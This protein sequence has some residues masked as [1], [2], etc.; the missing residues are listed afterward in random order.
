MG[1]PGLSSSVVCRLLE[2]DRALGW[3]DGRCAE[4]VGVWRGP[5]DRGA[6]VPWGGPGYDWRNPDDPRAVLE[7]ALRRLSRRARRELWALVEPADER[8]RRRWVADPF[9]PLE[10]PWW[11]R[12]WR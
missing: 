9:A 11:V 1:V 4:A 3:P 6:A 5:R 10:L 7:V 12:T 8:R 2:V